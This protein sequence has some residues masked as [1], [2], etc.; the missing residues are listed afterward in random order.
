[1]KTKFSILIVDDNKM[2]CVSLKDILADEGFTI[3]IVNNGINAIKLSQNN[4]YDLALIDFKLPDISGIEL[5]NNLVNLSPTMEFILI[6]ANATLDSAIDAV[7]QERVISY[8]RKPL[9]MARLLSTLKQVSRRRKAEKKTKYL[10]RQLQEA[11]SKVKLLSGIIPICSS[12]KKIRDNTG[13]WEQIESYIRDHSEAKF[14]HGICPDCSK[15]LYPDLY[16]A[17]KKE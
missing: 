12:C 8:E 4:K 5:I 16:D 3:A 11:L 7:K 15:K 17:K 13:Y 14:S 1:M 6:T 10:V 9:D 2:L